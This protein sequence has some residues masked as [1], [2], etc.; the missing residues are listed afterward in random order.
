MMNN[1]KF[2]IDLLHYFVCELL[3]RQK[4]HHGNEMQ[5]R[6]HTSLQPPQGLYTRVSRAVPDLTL[7]ATAASISKEDM[8]ALQYKIPK[9]EQCRPFCI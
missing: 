3:H 2:F 4:H 9:D 1:Y 8:A 7:E 6:T 5:C